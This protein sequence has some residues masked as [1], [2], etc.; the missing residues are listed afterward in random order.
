LIVLP[1][2]AAFVATQCDLVTD[3]PYATVA[4]AWVYH[5]GGAF[6]GVPASN[7]FGWLLPRSLRSRDYREPKAI[8][9]SR[10]SGPPRCPQSLSSRVNGSPPL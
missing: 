8:K 2:A 10:P 1:I 3:A 7:F 6:F 4:K 5:D 9:L